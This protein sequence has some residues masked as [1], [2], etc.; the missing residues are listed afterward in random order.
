MLIQSLRAFAEH[1]LA[2]A[3][4]DPAFERLPVKYIVPIGADGSYR[5][6][7]EQTVGD[8]GPKDRGLVY[9]VPRIGNRTGNVKP[10]FLVDKRTYALGPIATDDVKTASKAEAHMRAAVEQIEEALSDTG[11]QALEALIRFYN[12][13]DDL[14][15]ARRDYEMMGV[16]MESGRLSF[17]V[18]D[19]TRPVFERP[20][21]R[22]W[23]ASRA[24]KDSSDDVVKGR[25]LGCGRRAEIIERHDIPIK[26]VPGSNSSGAKLVSVNMASPESWG[27]ERATGC[28]MCGACVQAYSR[29]LNELLSRRDTRV[30]I[31]PWAKANTVLLVWSDAGPGNILSMLDDPQPES[32]RALMSSPYTAT[33]PLPTDERLHVVALGSNNARIVVRSWLDLPAV[34]AYANVAKWFEDLS[35]RGWAPVWSR[36]PTRP[37]GKEEVEGHALPEAPNDF[38]ISDRPSKGEMLSVAGEMTAYPSIR[39]LLDVLVRNPGKDAPPPWAGAGIYAAAITGKRLPDTLL[40][41]AIGRLG[42]PAG[43][44]GKMKC[45]WER[46]ESMR[47]C[48]LVRLSLNRS[49]HEGE[50]PM[51]QELDPSIDDAAYQCGRLFAIMVGIQEAAAGYNLNATIMDRYYRRIQTAPGTIIPLLLSLSRTHLSTLRRRGNAGLAHN[52]GDE[53]DNTLARIHADFPRTLDLRGQGRFALG[54]GHQRAEQS[55]IRK[56]RARADGEEGTMQDVAE[57]VE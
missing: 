45:N 40:S 46:A 1:N 15:A 20:V 16:K 14:G 9:T 32:I 2:D 10:C 37:S 31:G 7:I 51:P 19:D 13:P 49:K 35:L 12:S 22:G 43:P 44:E 21:L 36:R 38:A 24:T 17:K 48:A 11:D 5:G 33:A 3:L 34:E 52:L 57:N 26:G 6:V 25:C 18:G 56:E 50:V 4:A 41:L 47:L 30:V 27:W 8:G 39:E 29:A 53:L 55:R 23:W 54:F 42:L 28:P